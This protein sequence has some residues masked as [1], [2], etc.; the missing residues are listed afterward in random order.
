MKK[1]IALLIVALLCNDVVVAQGS[2]PNLIPYRKGNLWGYCDSNKKIIITPQFDKPVFFEYLYSMPPMSEVKVAVVAKNKKEGL[3]SETGNL[4]IPC[5]FDEVGYWD[6]TSNMFLAKKGNNFY[7]LDMKT[8]KLILYNFKNGVPF[9]HLPYQME[10]IDEIKESALLDIASDNI[11]I[12]AVSKNQFSIIRKSRRYVNNRNE[13]RFDTIQLAASNIKAISKS[14]TLFFINQHKKW[15]IISFQKKMVVPTSFDT[16]KNIWWGQVF[17][18]QKGN[19]LGAVWPYKNLATPVI[20][21]DV[22][23]NDYGDG[24]LV[25]RNNKWGVLVDDFKTEFLIDTIYYKKYDV[26]TY[27]KLVGLTDNTGKFLGYVNFNG[28]KYWD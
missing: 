14:D 9:D 17:A 13:I 7:K 20:Y 8:N 21:Q 4:L 2:L 3:L 1:V 11:S 12:T 5:E 18:V 15:G 24:F 6:D 27:S 22:K 26:I 10:R 25:K 28:T 23:N 19:K 16:I